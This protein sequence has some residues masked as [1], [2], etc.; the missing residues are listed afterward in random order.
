MAATWS[1]FGLSPVINLNIAWRYFHLR[2]RLPHARRF[3][4][5]ETSNKAHRAKRQANDLPSLFVG[6]I[7]LPIQWH[8]KTEQA[9]RMT[10]IGAAVAGII[11]KAEQSAG[12]KARKPAN[13]P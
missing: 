11:S 2:R 13:A 8:P 6:R 12:G 9:V 10:S 1:A 4:Q 5:S 3:G 7:R